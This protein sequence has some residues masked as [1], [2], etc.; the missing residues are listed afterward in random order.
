MMF[1][2][3]QFTGYQQTNPLTIGQTQYVLFGLSD[4]ESHGPL[5]IIPSNAKVNVN[6]SV[7]YLATPWFSII[8]F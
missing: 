4:A 1:F 3:D 8:R 6:L 7:T 2:Y 5:A